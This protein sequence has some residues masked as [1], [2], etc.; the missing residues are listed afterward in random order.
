MKDTE[1]HFLI[2]EDNPNDAELM[3]REL[4]KTGLKHTAER[5]GTKK[6][7]VKALD[8]FAPDLILADFNLP[9]FD[10]LSAL[11][12]AKQKTPDVPFI[13]ISGFIGEELAVEIVKS[14]A[15]DYILKDRISRL[16]PS[17]TRAL[18]ETEDRAR[19]RDAERQLRES[20]RRLRQIIDLVPHLIFVKD[21]DG[22]YLLVNKAVAEAFGTTVNNVVN[23]TDS[24]LMKSAEESRLAHENDLWVIK[25]H[26]PRL[27][28]EQQFT[29][30]T[31][32]LRILQTVK[33]PMA[34]EGA[35]SPA[36]LGVSIDIT[37]QKKSE[38]KIHEQAALLDIAS[39][40]IVVCDMN[41]TI[42]YWNKGA[43]NLY[44]WSAEEV[45]G[46]NFGPL[47]FKLHPTHFTEA[48]SALLANGKWDGEMHQ[49][50][51]EGGILVI[52][53]RWTLVRDAN[54]TPRSIL[55]L[56]SDITEKKKFEAQFLRAQRMESIGTLAGGIAHD[57]NNV[58]APILLTIQ[59]LRRKLPDE[60]S[61]RMLST[62]ES[63][64]KRGAEMVQQ[65][66]TFTRGA[67]GEK[68]VL[69]PKHL[70]EEFEKIV[71]ETFQ[72]SMKIQTRTAVDL[73][74]VRGDPT[75]LHQ[76]LMN[77]CVNARDAMLPN[78]GTLVIHA[79]N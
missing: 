24:E 37:E 58:L 33:M 27:I 68:I 53:S 64:T 59:N 41:D 7:F 49:S 19:R 30:S 47:A 70:I 38:D 35:D 63:S 31:G 18:K 43:E 34:M 20:E 42:L 26:Q 6:A 69:Q 67:E 72:R 73:R 76:V 16:V 13:I 28:P 9:S 62:V 79:E 46:K 2:L 36:V 40:A 45:T 21:S 71:R 55:I 57:L 56:N 12:L 11:K 44:G 61:Q 32:T 39:D 54:G 48:R 25:N 23:H 77:L 50:T 75:Q 66:L 60:R 5:V 51:K 29:D 65:V 17:V 4:G 14:G 78:G 8:E 1:L 52:Q 74:T 10:G 3:I 15:T 22:R